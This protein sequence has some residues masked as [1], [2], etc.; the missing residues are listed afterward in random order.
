MGKAEEKRSKKRKRSSSD[1]RTT[2]NDIKGTNV[3]D[4]DGE[5]V[6]R[7]SDIEINLTT[8]NPTRLIIHKGF[9]GRYLRIN[10][11][12]VEKITRDSIHLWISPAK[13][14]V[15]TRI[16]DIEANEIGRVEE[17]HVR[18]DGSLEYV[19]AVTSVI[20]T[21]NDEDKGDT[22]MVPMSA[23]E[24]MS[25]SLPP[26]AFEEEPIPTHVALNKKIIHIGADEIID[27]G[28]DCIR[29]RGKKEKYLGKE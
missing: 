17:A 9:F 5:E 12:Y 23:F 10:L 27:V 20:Q 19:K 21:T 26:T 6:G 11:K 13:N 4:A 18:K 15:G 3:Y 24:D 22:F 16:L 25:V 1:G 8:L 7:V 28:K 14:L 2:F 29:L